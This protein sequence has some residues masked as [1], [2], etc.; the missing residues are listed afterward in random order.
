M[1]MKDV[2]FDKK[3]LPFPALEFTLPYST[4]SIV[5]PSPFA[6]LSLELTNMTN[7]YSVVLFS[8]SIMV[9]VLDS[10][11]EPNRVPRTLPLHMNISNHSLVE[12]VTTRI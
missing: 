5:I 7:Q 1:V 2:F 3:I 10:Q 8:T 9:Q 4:Y 11:R 12:R 6:R